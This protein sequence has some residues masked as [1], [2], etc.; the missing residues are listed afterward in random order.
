M[1]VFRR[2]GFAVTSSLYGTSSTLTWLKVGGS[3]SSDVQI[4]SC[5]VDVMAKHLSPRQ[6][7]GVIC[8]GILSLLSPPLSYL[9]LSLCAKVGPIYMGLMVSLLQ[10][11]AMI[12]S[13]YT[14][15]VHT[16]LCGFSWTTNGE[17]LMQITGEK[18]RQLWR[19]DSLA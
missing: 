10:N 14:M 4:L 8:T 9:P 17:H 18:K 16:E 12:Y 2:N 7:A 15:G 5:N 1:I 11:S 3:C 19:V 13:K 6:E